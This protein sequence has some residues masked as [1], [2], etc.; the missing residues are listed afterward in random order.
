MTI[1]IFNLS[2]HTLTPPEVSLLSRGLTFAP[3]AGPNPFQLFIDLNRFIRNLTVKRFFQMKIEKNNDNKIIEETL[4]SDHTPDPE[5]LNSTPSDLTALLHLEQ[6][7]TEDEDL[8]VEFLSQHLPTSPPVSHTSLH[9]PSIFNPTSSKG[10]YIHTF[11]QVVYEDLQKLC[12]QN[13]TTRGSH[14]NLSTEESL[15]MANLTKNNNII[16]KSADKGGGI[17]VQNRSNYLQESAR[18]LSD[19]NTY[20]KLEKDPLPEFTSEAH[21]LIND[22]ASEGIINKTETAFL[23]HDL[24]NRPYFYHLPKIHKDPINP[25]GR[26]IVAAMESVTSYFSIYID[27]FLQPLAQNLPSYV[28]DSIHLL[29]ML[30]NY[31]WEPSYMWLS[32]DVCSLYTSIPHDVG[33]SAVKHF[34]EE[35]SNMNPRQAQFILEATEYC[36]THNYFEF[37]GD[38]YLQTHGTAMG[39]NFAPSYANLTMG[40]WEKRYI[41]SNNPF[42]SQIIFYGRYI[43][44]VVIIWDGTPLTIQPFIDHCNQNNMGLTFTSVQN[45]DSLA[46]LD[47]LLCHDQQTIY[48]QNYNKPTAGNSYLHFKSCHHP[49]WINNIPK[50]QFCRL[51]QN[52]TRTEDFTTHGNYL[53]KKF[54]EKGYPPK[55]IDDAFTF[56]QENEPRNNRKEGNLLDPHKQ[57]LRF[58]TKFHNRYKQMEHILKKHWPILQADPHLKASIPDRPLVSYR[59]AR[60]LKN[61]IAPSKIQKSSTTPSAPLTFLNIKGMFQ[62]RKKSCLTCKHVTH[63]LK[64]FSTKGQKYT[65]PDFFNC[66]TEFV[67]YCMSCPCGLLYVGRTIRTLRKRFGEHRRFVEAGNDK[68]SVPKHFLQHHHQSS[69][70]LKVWII[71]SIPKNLPPAERFKR[72]CARESYWIYRLDS[73]TPGGL[74]EEIEVNPLL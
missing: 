68:R 42:S 5:D 60:N 2:D 6:L 9:P 48:T 7:Y 30:A 23:K 52:C 50:S 70:D 17:V 22:A 51:K 35:D 58:T 25:P 28:R 54:L 72:L 32:L 43:D 67:I 19:A 74:N 44:D 37:N 12:Q 39:T 56:Y 33:L 24:Y 38:F 4:D 55:L 57:P 29:D 27:Q 41:W 21:Q 10:S 61:N 71:E 65:I 36:L 13:R 16:I 14:S 66:S 31:T 46:F 18:L 73:M 69:A 62:C 8:Y 3:T 49:R 34:L 59:R 53:T 1:K 40:L 45:Q 64:E 47:L 11:Y 15:A 20:T 26:P 63:G